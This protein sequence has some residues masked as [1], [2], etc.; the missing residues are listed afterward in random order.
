MRPTRRE[1]GRLMSS[2]I[3]TVVVTLTVEL[4]MGGLKEE[5]QIR[6]QVLPW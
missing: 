1:R 6:D 5:V 4:E 2:E 3:K